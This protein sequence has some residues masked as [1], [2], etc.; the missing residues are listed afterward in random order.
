MRMLVARCVCVFARARARVFAHA[1]VCPKRVHVCALVC[2]CVCV[3]AHTP[4]SDR[5]AASS[6]A[7]PVSGRSCRDAAACASRTTVTF[8]RRDATRS[9]SG[10]AS[11]SLSEAHSTTAPLAW[12]GAGDVGAGTWEQGG[13]CRE[14]RAGR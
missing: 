12:P 2:A 6:R 14:V 5:K 4:V 11:S 1:C 10:P 3:R 9:I 7:G 13:G 8:P